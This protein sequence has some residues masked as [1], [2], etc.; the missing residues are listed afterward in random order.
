MV[1]HLFFRQKVSDVNY[2]LPLYPFTNIIAII[3]L[4]SVIIIMT[5][6]PDMKIAVYLMPLWIGI[7]TVAY[8]VKS[9]L[10][11]RKV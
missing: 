7:L 8:I 1:G 3:C 2:K 11:S 10:L 9:V 6:M 5:K 4:I